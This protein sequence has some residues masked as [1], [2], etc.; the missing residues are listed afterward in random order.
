MY[1][2]YF[3]NK[4]NCKVNFYG[5]DDPFA[6]TRFLEIGYI[7]TMEGVVVTD[8]CI[9]C[10][11]PN[12]IW[13]TYA[14]PLIGFFQG[15]KL[16]A[17]T[18]GSV[19]YDILDTAFMHSL[20]SNNDLKI[21]TLY[22]VY[23]LADEGIR[24]RLEEL[25]GKE[26]SGSTKVNP[27]DLILP[28]ILLAFADSVN[29]CTFA[30]FT[31]LLLM[32][33]YSVGRHKVISTG[34]SFI[35]AVFIGYYAL[36]V[37]LLSILVR[38]PFIGKFAGIVGLIM[39]AYAIA[40]GLKP[41]F[42]S[43]LPKTLRRFIEGWIHKS[44]VSTTASFALGLLASF[45]LLPCTGGPYLVGLGILSTLRSS[46][47]AYI[48][49]TI[50]GAIFISPLIIILTALSV[51]HNLVRKIKAFRSSK[52]GIM[53]LISGIILALICTYLLAS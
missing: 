23:S 30:L 42:K 25:F 51:S 28:L 8:L 39:G 27:L 20:T 37:G 52:L 22:G 40:C 2:S 46:I 14:Q 18:V 19:N 6:S 7:L 48:L 50:Y 26:K 3:N 53:E 36:G 16:R 10:L 43:S 49:L 17:I 5:L 13:M 24:T 34:L 38:I 9:S 32:T 33:I 31:A 45:I 35:L 29:P 44:Y 47:Q 12:V 21:F 41:K 11:D 15:G 1:L 4:S